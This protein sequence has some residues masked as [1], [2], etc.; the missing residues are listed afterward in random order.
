[1]L[2]PKTRVKPTIAVHAEFS[3]LS[4]CPLATRFH[5]L[6]EASLTPVAATISRIES[7]RLVVLVWTV[8]AMLVPL[9]TALSVP[10]A[11]LIVATWTPSASVKL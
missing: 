8:K 11:E 5:G 6:A 10:A 7:D 9:A 1:M 2:P 3:G 4:T